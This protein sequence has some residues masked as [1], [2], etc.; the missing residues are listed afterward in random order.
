MLEPTARVERRR[1]AFGDHAPARDQRPRPVGRGLLPGLAA[2]TRVIANSG[3]TPV[4][5]N[6]PRGD[7]GGPREA[8]AAMDEDVLVGV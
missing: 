4:S 1:V 7:Y 5:T 3:S 8:A 6:S 2:R